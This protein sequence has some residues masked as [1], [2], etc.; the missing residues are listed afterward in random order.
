MNGRGFESRP[1]LWISL[2]F[3]Q[4]YDFSIKHPL[5][6]GHFMKN[7]SLIRSC[8]LGLAGT[9]LSTDERKFFA[10]SQ[11]FGFIL[12]ARNCET[13]GQVK[14]LCADL[15]ACIGRH[16]APILID[17][18]GGR[19]QR[20]RKPHWLEMPAI[21]TIGEL[22]HEN[23]VNAERAAFL[24]SQIIGLQLR[25]CG[26]SVNCAPCLDLTI[27]GAHEIIG[28]R[29]FGDDPAIVRTLGRRACEGLLSVGIMP[30]IKH[31]PGHGRASVDSHVSL[32]VID[33]DRDTLEATDFETFRQHPAGIWGMTGHLLL[34]CV[35]PESC[36]TF[37]A[38]GIE[39]VIRQSIG[40]DGL[41][42]SDDLSMQA[43]AGTM[44]ERT[45]AA[46]K[47]GCD[48]VL[49]C[50][51][52]MDEM[53]EVLDSTPPLSG[54]ARDRSVFKPDGDG[55]TLNIADLKMEFDELIHT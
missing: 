36:I 17:Q 47:A 52:K 31:L 54:K 50:N 33:T 12:F 15:R 1:K 21:A 25:D 22:A 23:M 41:L 4:W 29:S 51:G 49:H 34:K 37:S 8:I 55:S 28:D 40:F 7:D 18:E 3:G 24:H 43:L 32:P 44:S 14:D 45:K 48:I 26:V 2:T 9:A 20:L 46:I 30:V 53:M 39:T 42:L 11:P 6:H 27:K 38:T 10:A 5:N 19:V 13:P 16:D 35:D